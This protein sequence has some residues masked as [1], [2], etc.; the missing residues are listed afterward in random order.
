MTREHAAHGGQNETP[1]Q[2]SEKDDHGAGR[3]EQHA[4]AEIGLGEDERHGCRDHERGRD[5]IK[6]ARDLLDLEPV[7]VA[8]ERQHERDLGELRGLDREE[9]EIEPALRAHADMAEEIDEHEQEQ[10]DEIGRISERHPNPQIGERH[11]DEKPQ[12]HGKAGRL[13]AHPRIDA[14]VRHRIEHG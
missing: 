7:I 10:R 2:A 1:A 4:R 13:R 12:A 6:Q 8:R 5:E 11:H 14:A 9:A 3:R